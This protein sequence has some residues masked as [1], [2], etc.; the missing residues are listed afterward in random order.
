MVTLHLSLPSQS[1]EISFSLTRD[2]TS[3]IL[4][5][6]KITKYLQSLY[7]TIGLLS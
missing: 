2:S 6:S 5:Q 4:P 3:K 1:S 7:T